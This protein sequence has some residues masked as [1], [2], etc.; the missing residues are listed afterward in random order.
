MEVA[1]E[2]DRTAWNELR[3]KKEEKNVH[4]GYAGDTFSSQSGGTRTST[5]CWECFV[6]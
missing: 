1:G 6:R 5:R 3:E 4:G 2:E